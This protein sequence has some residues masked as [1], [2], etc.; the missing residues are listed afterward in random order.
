MANMRLTLAYDGSDFEGWQAQ[1]G[2]RP[3]RT[4]QAVLEAALTRLGGQP[5]AVAAA[6]RTDAGVH[7]IG[8]VVSFEFALEWP[9][10]RVQRA[11]NGLLPPD[12]R[13]LAAAH[14]SAD[15]HAR[16]SACAKLYRYELDTGPVQLPTRRSLAAH[17]P[18]SLAPEPVARV[19]ALYLGRQDFAALRSTG[20]S[21]QTSVRTVLRSE[22]RWYGATLVY[23]V[24]ADGFLRKMVRSM[25]GGLI[26]AGRG[27]CAPEALSARL[28]EGDR[29][30]WPAPAAAHGLTLVAV[31]YDG[32]REPAPPFAPHSAL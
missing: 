17:V 30:R 31:A 11:L 29:R 13:V 9:A 18:W 22:V 14:A 26:A 32:C 24:V 7:A 15:F 10:E 3:A 4:V 25:V 21:V 2:A 8:Q 5:V 27:Q 19:A 28:A 1:A 23:E 12:V 16:R 6:G 20:S